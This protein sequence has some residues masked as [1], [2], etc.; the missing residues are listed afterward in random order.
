MSLLVTRLVL[1]GFRSYPSLTL[2]LDEHLTVLVGPNAAGKT[3]VLEAIQILVEGESFRRPKW[4]DV[5]LHGMD[6]ASMALT[7]EGDGR[8]VTYEV[9]ID[10]GSGR[11]THKV[12]GKAFSR[13]GDA[14]RTLT[15][16]VFTPDDLRLVKD[17]AEKRRSAIDAMGARLSVAYSR[18]RTEYDRTLRQRNAALKAGV[19]DEELVALDELLVR[20]GLRLRASRQRLFGRLSGHLVQVYGSI[21]GGETLGARYITSTERDGIECGVGS[22]EDA[23]WAALGQ[24]RAAERARQT[25]MCGPHRDDI[26]FRIG[27]SPAREFASQGQ[28]RSIALA[29]KMAEAAVATEVKGGRPLLLLD[30][31]M[32]ELDEERRIALTAFIR[33]ASQAV[34]TTTNLGYFSEDLLGEGC[35]VRVG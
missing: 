29:W 9:A 13:A 23:F 2:G 11:K 7:A 15:C 28:Q 33:E 30:D 26:E 18:L 32:S 31:V 10:R 24:S 8:V 17:S 22:E 27:D 5:V 16:V 21:S 20:C 12:N 1:D 14:S 19:S 6:R 34:V 4:S 3:N 35:V 25:T